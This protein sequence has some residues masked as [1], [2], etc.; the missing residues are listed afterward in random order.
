VSL[1]SVEKDVLVR[2]YEDLEKRFQRV[3]EQLDAANGELA[4]KP[5]TFVYSAEVRELVEKRSAAR[6]AGRMDEADAI[7][8]EL[9]CKYGVSITDTPA[10]NILNHSPQTPGGDA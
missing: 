2:M 3:R 7:R 4:A 10:G 5:Q 9:L 8:K 6:R 1:R